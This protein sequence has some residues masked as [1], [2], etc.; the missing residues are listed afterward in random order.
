[1]LNEIKNLDKPPNKKLFT[2]TTNSMYTN[3][4]MEHAITVITWWLDD[5]KMQNKLPCLFPLEAVK[6]AMKL[7]M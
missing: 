7:I 2:C 4:D 3:I 5:L 6:D 1:M